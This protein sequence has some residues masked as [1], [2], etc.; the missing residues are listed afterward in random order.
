QIL[1]NIKKGTIVPKIEQFVKDAKQEGILIHGCFMM[2]NRGETKETI[3]KTVQWAKKLDPDTAQFFPI[4]VYPG[5]EA[6]TWA[7]DNNFLKTTDWSQWLLPDGTHNTIVSTDKLSAE[8]LVR[9]CDKARI[10]FYLRPEF[11]FRKLGQVIKNPIR[12]T[13]RFL[14]STWIF[15]K[16]LAKEIKETLFSKPTSS[17]LAAQELPMDK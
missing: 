1:N 12:E 5:T 14:I 16:Y 4:M 15:S 17:D 7:K 9:E 11:A 8:D 3:Q 10:A 13:P 2:G 6:F